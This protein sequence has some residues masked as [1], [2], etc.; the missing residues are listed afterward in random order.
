[1]IYSSIT[2]LEAELSRP[3]IGGVYPKVTS[4]WRD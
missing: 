2:R 4:T 3:A 1:L